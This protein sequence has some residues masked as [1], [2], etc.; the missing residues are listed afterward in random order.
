[1]NITPNH[2]LK[3]KKV[4]QTIDNEPVSYVYPTKQA[5]VLYNK[6]ILNGHKATIE[7]VK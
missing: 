4:T 5:E 7:E 2:L 3:K 6:L 1:M